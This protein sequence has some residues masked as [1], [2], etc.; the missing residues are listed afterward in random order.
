MDFLEIFSK[1]SKFIPG[2]RRPQK[3][4]TLNEKLMWTGIVV[5]IYYLLT[6]IPLYGIPKVTSDYLAQLRFIFAG[7]AGTL[8]ELGISPIVTAGIILELL[9]GSKIIEL[10]LTSPEDR[11]KFTAA[12]R[13]FAVLMII[14]EASIYVFGGRY[15][16]IGT[17]ITLSLALI[18]FAQLFIGSYIILLLDELTSTWGIGSGISLFIAA[19]VAQTI[20]WETFSPLKD[21]NGNYIGAIPALILSGGTEWYRP[22]LP[23]AIGLIAS[24]AVFII[25]IIAQTV[26]IEIPISYRSFKGMRGKYPI[27]LLYISNIPIIF[28]S[29]LFADVFLVSQMLWTRFSNTSNE[30]LR[31]LV[32][33]LGVYQTTETG[34]LVAVGGL[35]YYMTAPYGIYAVFQDPVRSVAYTILLIC[36][37]IL[38]GYI[39]VELSG[40]D[41]KSIAKQIVSGGM[42]IPGFRSS[43]KVV[44]NVLRRYIYPVTVVGAVLVGIIAAFADFIGSLGRGM[45]ILLATM[46]IWQFYEAIARE[47][48]QEA[49]PLVR[50]MMRM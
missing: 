21:Q 13:T 14:L 7:Q 36:I 33:L 16:R 3:H 18:L 1:A 23:S 35:A 9:V 50:K 39:W 49:H 4:V 38:F 27:S 26:K 45:G 42:T 32:S 11:A 22:G 17:N 34:N 40:M 10:D 25:V 47:R 30:I 15:G 12:Q 31:T 28:A 41:P 24:V 19:G 5:I 2:V 48:I 43:I 29:T 8:V 37:S 46:I 6:Q 44:E 20:F